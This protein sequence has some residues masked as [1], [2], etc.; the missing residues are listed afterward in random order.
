MS[1]IKKMSLS[2]IK[3]YWRNPKN[4]GNVQ[5]VKELIEEMGYTNFIVVDKEMTI[6]AGHSRY[7]ALMEL[8]YKNIQVIVADISENLAKE[9]RIIDNKIAEKNAWDEDLLLKEIAEIDQTG[10]I[11]ELFPDLVLTEE[12]PKE[13]FE[14]LKEISAKAI[15]AKREQET[16]SII[17]PH[18]YAE[19]DATQS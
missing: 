14:E 7:K 12:K 5:N 15:K 13:V 2:A 18:C 11:A 19:F 6:I 4:S 1:Q 10:Q 16:A 8:G 9:Y 17:C 3:P